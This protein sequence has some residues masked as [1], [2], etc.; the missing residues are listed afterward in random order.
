[1]EGRG[2]FGRGEVLLDGE[3]KVVVD[4]LVRW[5][6]GAIDLGAWIVGRKMIG[7]MQ[8]FYDV[9]RMPRPHYP[10]NQFL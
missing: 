2:G 6:R 1:V 8:N 10:I 9:Y 7:F 5:C 3:F 4:I